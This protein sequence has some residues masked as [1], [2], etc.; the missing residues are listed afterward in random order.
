MFDFFIEILRSWAEVLSPPWFTFFGTMLEEIIAPIPSPLVM[1]LGG[2]LAESLHKNVSYLFLLAL[3]GTAGKTIGSYV[4]YLIA[5]KFENVLA[6][7]AGKW[8]G[9]SH[10]Q[11]ENIGARLGKGWKD[12]VAIFV[13]RALPIMPTAPVS[14]VAGI[15]KIDLKTYLV[16]SALGI[17]VR[18]MF[19]LYLGF[20][21]LGA[22]ENINSNLASWESVGSVIVLVL[23]AALILYI[24]KKRRELWKEPTTSET[25]SEK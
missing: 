6:T 17:F 23:V 4:I 25:S 21:S 8:I 19:Y 24:Y 2:S 16:S 20:T 11:I 22:L 15:L 9:I 14:F 5:D 7:R 18:N 13:L 1:T 10:T 3:T 12:N